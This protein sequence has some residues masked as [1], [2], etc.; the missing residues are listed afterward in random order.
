MAKTLLLMRHGKAQARREDLPDFDRRLTR[1]GKRAL[2]ATLRLPLERRR[3]ETPCSLWASPAVRTM[4]TAE[5]LETA[6]KAQ[7]IRTNPI[8]E[9]ACL[10]DQDPEAFLRELADADDG[11]IACIGHNPFIEEMLALLTGARLHVAP[12][13]IAAMEI[14]E[15]RI[16]ALDGPAAAASDPAEPLA[17][18][19]WIV[20]GAAVAPWKTLCDLEDVVKAAQ[21]RMEGRLAAFMADPD[22]VEALHKLRVSIRTLR[23][24]YK[25][26]AP[27]QKGSQARAVQ[28]DL[29]S[30]VVPTS[31]LRELDVLSAEAD[32][33]DPPSA[34]LVEACRELRERER[35][36]VLEALGGEDAAKAVERA[37]KAAEGFAWKRRIRREGLLP[38]QVAQR[39]DDM[40][41][42]VRAM[43]ERADLAD[44]EATHDLRKAA[45]RVRYAAENFAAFL[46]PGRADD[47]VAR[48]KAV[49]DELGALCDARVNVEIIRDFPRKGL[50][51]QAL[52]D[53]DAL[54]AENRYF[55][56]S[57]LRG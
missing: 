49:Q 42:G 18:L 7:G 8:E 9:R 31:R 12:G 46:D 51:A 5:C 45:K 50:P 11:L 57:A 25:F 43:Q 6:L 38:Q 52:R 35:D 21:E 24:L 26:L 44:A 32:A 10:L 22:D 20:Q 4:Q 39:F 47:A 13:G 36:R 53:L 56:A 2:Q 16:A 3:R 33:M 19:L 28:R 1:A 48:M 23:S 55:I 15:S 17:R 34:D 30:V 27:F 41:A 29:R 54:E 14:D 40:D 37:R